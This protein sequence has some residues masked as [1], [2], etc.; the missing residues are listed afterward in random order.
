MVE[1]LGD[2]GF[3]VW[4]FAATVFTVLY[5]TLSRWYKSLM[6]VLIGVFVAGESILSLYIALR[7]WDVPVPAVEWVRLIIFWVLGLAM[8]I[9]VI[10]FLEIQFGKRGRALR[11]RLAEKRKFDDL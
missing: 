8:I 5:L 1:L 9:S 7:I 6:G 4:A 3:L 10:S 11:A 2:I